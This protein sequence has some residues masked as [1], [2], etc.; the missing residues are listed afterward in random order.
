MGAFRRMPAIVLYSVVVSQTN[1]PVK[2]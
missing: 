1:Q 2:V